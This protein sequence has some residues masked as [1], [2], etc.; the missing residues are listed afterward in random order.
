MTSFKTNKAKKILIMP[1]NICPVECQ[2]NT[3]NDKKIPA[4]NLGKV[5]NINLLPV[6]CFIDLY[7]LTLRGKNNMD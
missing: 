7:D 5:L 3:I 2:S 6:I 1:V 4:V